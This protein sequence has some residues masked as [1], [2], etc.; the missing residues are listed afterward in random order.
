[1]VYTGTSGFSLFNSVISYFI[2]S[3]WLHVVTCSSSEAC[4]L[5][6]LDRFRKGGKEYTQE[7][8]M[9]MKTQDF[10]YV[11]NKAQAESKVCLIGAKRND[12]LLL[13]CMLR[14]A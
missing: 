2:F 10:R 6:E 9:L 3:L 1:M 5:C 7:E 8:I 11:L 13:F 12:G 14:R 4:I